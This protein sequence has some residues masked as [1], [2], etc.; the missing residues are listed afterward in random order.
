[1]LIHDP[2][3]IKRMYPGLHSTRL[4]TFFVISPQLANRLISILTMKSPKI[5]PTPTSS[6]VNIIECRRPNDHQSLLRQVQKTRRRHACE[7]SLPGFSLRKC[8]ARLR[9]LRNG[10]VSRSWQFDS[11]FQILVVEMRHVQEVTPC[12]LWMEIP[13]VVIVVYDPGDHDSMQR[14]TDLLDMEPSAWLPQ[15]C[16]LALASSGGTTSSP[17]PVRRL[18]ARAKRRMGMLQL[19]DILHSGDLMSLLQWTLVVASTRKVTGP[20]PVACEES[21]SEPSKPGLWSKFDRPART[22]MLRM[23]TSKVTLRSATDSTDTRESE[24]QSTVPKAPGE[25]GDT[26]TRPSTAPNIQ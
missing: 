9:L 26:V 17:R 16:Q 11:S 15:G 23:M 18:K 4:R 20:N 3:H 12:A 22:K 5:N 7:Y 24:S 2:C 13:S 6:L 19:F 25:Y 14:V 1:M 21:I 10:V 8:Q